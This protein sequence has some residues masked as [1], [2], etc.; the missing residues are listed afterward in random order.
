M[1][2]KVKPVDLLAG[3]VDKSA[4][5]EWYVTDGAT[6]VGPV[7]FDLLARGITAGKVPSE[8][9]VRHVG[10]PGWRRLSDLV[11]HDPTFD[12]RQ[13][14][15]VLRRETLPSI[16]VE[17]DEDDVVEVL[18]EDALE[19][20]FDDASNLQEA[21]LM[22]LERAVR[23]CEADAALIHGI[24][25]DGASV[26][27]SHGPRMFEQLGDKLPNADPVLIGNSLLAE[28]VPGIG[29]RATKSRLS[30]LGARVESAFMVPV[31]V[32]G[33]LIALMELGRVKPYRGRDVGVC[34]DLVDTLALAIK[35]SG[36][37]REWKA[38]T[39]PPRP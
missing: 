1:A 36:W 22:L 7:G 26:V 11:E 6:A 35:R 10:W 16:D 24:R 38:P 30:R 5:D 27:C 14:M 21:L 39:R 18:D 31:L 37:V 32:D 9:F 23:Q 8:A 19:G 2:G 25:G 15:R 17:P 13:T 3:L 12:P 20:S 34:E 4:P 28:P 29:G 33:R